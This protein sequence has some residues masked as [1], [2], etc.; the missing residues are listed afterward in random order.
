M[1]RRAAIATLVRSQLYV[2]A[3]ALLPGAIYALTGESGKGVA[4]SLVCSLIPLPFLVWSLRKQLW[5]Q[6]RL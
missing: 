5:R 6:D 4:V 2:C 1:I 3:C